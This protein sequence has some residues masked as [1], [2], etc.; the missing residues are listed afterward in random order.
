[1]DIGR[2]VVPFGRHSTCLPNRKRP[3][4]SFDIVSQEGWIDRPGEAIVVV[5]Y[6]LDPESVAKM[7]QVDLAEL[8]AEP[9]SQ[10][11][12]FSFHGCTGGVSSFRGRPPWEFHGQG[13][14]LLFVL[15]GQSELTVLNGSQREVRTL[16][17]GQLAIVPQSHW[18][19]NNA[20]AGVTMLWITPTDGN[21][22]SWDEPTI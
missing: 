18:H 19:S 12:N 20:L 22:H 3:E 8:T 9:E 16:I 17:A 15:A 11:G 7:V 21:E 1:L 2:F 5:V 14:E 4:G 6:H 10:I 13:D